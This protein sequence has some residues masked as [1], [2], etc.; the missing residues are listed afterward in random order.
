ML[1]FRQIAL[2][3]LPFGTLNKSMSWIDKSLYLGSSDWN[4]ALDPD[5]IYGGLALEIFGLSWWS[6]CSSPSICNGILVKCLT[7]SAG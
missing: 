5:L 2:A 1:T 6:G 3:A 4:P 7:N